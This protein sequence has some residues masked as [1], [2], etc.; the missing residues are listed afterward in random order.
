MP[1]GSLVRL[2]LGIHQCTGQR[3]P[4]V[5]CIDGCLT[6]VAASV[7]DTLHWFTTVE[8]VTV[9][10]ADSF[11]VTSQAQARNQHHTLQ[12]PLHVRD[13][14]VSPATIAEWCMQQDPLALIA[15]YVDLDS[16]GLGCC[17]F[18][19]HHSDGVDTH[20]SLYVYDPSFPD[21]CCWYCH[22]W[23]RGGSVFDFLRYYYGFEPRELW[24]HILAGRRF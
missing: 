3:Y 18:G 15:R 8:R 13:V 16:K 6:P 19:W 24:S 14:G 20:P 1:L 22:V 11:L 4:F 2:P 10:A 21:L 23:K 17:P 5:A 9:P 7:A 12:K